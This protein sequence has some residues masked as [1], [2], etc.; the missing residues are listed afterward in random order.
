MC[1]TE[2][3][4]LSQNGQSSTVTAPRNRCSASL[5]VSLTEVGVDIAQRDLCAVGAEPRCVVTHTC[6]LSDAAMR[7]R[8][9]LARERASER[10]RL[11]V[12]EQQ[13]AI[14][15]VHGANGPTEL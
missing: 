14:K 13:P 12:K 5:T 6:E 8:R 7:V 4:H 10:E 2:L 3:L 1:E 11:P 9:R 15:R